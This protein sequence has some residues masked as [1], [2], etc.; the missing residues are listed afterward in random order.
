MTIF[1]EKGR[2]YLG[3]SGEEFLRKWDAGEIGPVPDTAEARPLMRVVIALPFAGRTL[4]F[5]R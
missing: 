4:D 5:A 3:I 2:R 1:A